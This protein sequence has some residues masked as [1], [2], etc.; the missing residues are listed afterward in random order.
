MPAALGRPIAK[1]CTTHDVDGTVEVGGAGPPTLSLR[2][3]VTGVALMIAQ[4]VPLCA[5][6]TAVR[7]ASREGCYTIYWFTPLSGGATVSLG[8]AGPAGP[9]VAYADSVPGQR[10]PSTASRS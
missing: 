7:I 8:V 3:V 5:S 1:T 10:K 2:T 9:F 6:S 4:N